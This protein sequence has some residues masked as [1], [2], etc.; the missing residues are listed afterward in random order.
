MC[1]LYVGVHVCI[2]EGMHVE[3]RHLAAVH[4]CGGQ[5]PCCSPCFSSSTVLALGVKL[6]SAGSAAGIF[7]PLSQLMGLVIPL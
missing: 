4:A 1:L 6:R 3:L 5:T 2:H 7:Y